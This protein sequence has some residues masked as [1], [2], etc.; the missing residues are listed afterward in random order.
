[1]SG[2][3]ASLDCRLLFGRHSPKPGWRFA[4]GLR[5]LFKRR[6]G[7]TMHRQSLHLSFGPR[8]GYSGKKQLRRIR[9]LCNADITGPT[10]H[11][12]E[13]SPDPQTRF[14]LGVKLRNSKRAGGCAASQCGFTSYQPVAWHPA[15]SRPS[16]TVV[17]DPIGRRCDPSLH[18]DSS[19]VGSDEW[20]NHSA[21]QRIRAMTIELH[22]CGIRSLPKHT[23][24]ERTEVW[25]ER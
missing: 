14:K 2:I 9:E 5:H 17:I 15:S 18:S 24:S 6:R 3:E 25:L 8:L 1:M 23:E 16:R 13:P 4:L 10:A 7:S 19:T 21:G 22:P 12:C 11:T 20:R